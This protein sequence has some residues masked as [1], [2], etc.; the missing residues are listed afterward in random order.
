MK[1]AIFIIAT[2]LVVTLLL[3]WFIGSAAKLGGPEDRRR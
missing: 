3:A 2:W 1:T